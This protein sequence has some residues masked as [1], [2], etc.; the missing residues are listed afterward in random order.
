MLLFLDL[1][2]STKVNLSKLQK[3]VLIYEIPLTSLMPKNLRL[4][5]GISTFNQGYF[6]LERNVTKQLI[7]LVEW[8]AFE[9]RVDTQM[10]LKSLSSAIAT[11]NRG[12]VEKFLWELTPFEKI[13]NSDSIAVDLT[14]LMLLRKINGK[15]KMRKVS[16]E[17]F[18]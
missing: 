18:D 7:D 2:S 5:N 16:I 17:T 13:T 14:H 8:F 9:Q 15:N 6:I 12:S 1:F 11:L 4:K 3:R 10:S